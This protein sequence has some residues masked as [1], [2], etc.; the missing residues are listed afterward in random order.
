MVSGF[1]LDY[2]HRCCIGVMKRIL[3]SLNSPKNNPQKVNLGTHQM[4]K[5]NYYLDQIRE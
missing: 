2:M 1:V 4:V 3:L 5:F